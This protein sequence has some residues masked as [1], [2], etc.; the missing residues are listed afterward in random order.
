M[1][2]PARAEQRASSRELAIVVLA[3]LALIGAVIWLSDGAILFTRPLWVDE[4]FT[5][6]VAS[7]PSPGDVIADLRLGADGGASLLHLLVWGLRAISGP[8]LPVALRAMSLLFTIGALLLVYVVLRRRFDVDSSVAG[9]LAVGSHGLVAAHAFE[10]RFYALWLLCSAFFAW[11]LSLNRN[12][13]PLHTGR[14]AIVVA[15]AAVLLCTSHW[16]GILSLALMCAAALASQGRR[17]RDGLR[18]IAPS[19]AGLVA[20]LAV[21]PLALGQRA[22]ITVDTWIPAFTTAQLSGLAGTFWTARVPLIAATLMLVGALVFARRDAVRRLEAGARDV[23]RDVG[24]VALLS[25][26]LMPLLLA[27][28]SLAGQ[29]S[30]ISRYAVPAVLAWGPFVALAVELVGRWPARAFAVVLLGFWWVSFQREAGRKRAFTAGLA[31]EARAIRQAESLGMP[32]VFQSL[33]ALYPSLAAERGRSSP[34]VFLDL[35]D[36]TFDALFPPNTPS[37]QHNKGIRLERDFARVHAARFGFPRLASQA[38][39]DSADRFLV[40]ATQLSGLA[41]AA[42][43]NHRATPVSE[44]LLRLDRRPGRSRPARSTSR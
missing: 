17:W 10:G 31:R 15:A 16:Y 23:A 18:V 38:E 36:S 34:A 35:P 27:L 43:P 19:V 44:N 20:V 40:F 2:A 37:Y 24:V 33:H 4:W 9:V 14:R 42:F 41:P 26:T 30:M 13:P 29:P 21:S 28:L 3:L 32:V 6:L 12:P 39:L 5:V 22:A 1:N 7:H 8:V 11:S 25:L